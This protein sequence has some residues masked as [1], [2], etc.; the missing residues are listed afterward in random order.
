M[1]TTAA[2]ATAEK[3]LMESAVP[4]PLA[5]HGI[6]DDGLPPPTPAQVEYWRDL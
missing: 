3:V 2:T 4:S 1:N 6:F 5:A